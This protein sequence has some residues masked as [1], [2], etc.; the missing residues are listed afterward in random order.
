[1]FAH[2]PRAIDGVFENLRKFL[3]L[4]PAKCGSEIR[5]IAR[6]LFSVN[7]RAAART[8]PRPTTPRVNRGSDRACH[9]YATLNRY[10][11]RTPLT[12]KTEFLADFAEF[13]NGKFQVFFRMSSRDLRSDSSSSAR[14]NRKKETDDVK[15][16]GEKPVSHFL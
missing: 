6:S 13:L 11:A 9:P 3:P 15:S 10:I 12:T 16:Q 1:M 7:P 2:V 14:H 5:A 4:V 8:E